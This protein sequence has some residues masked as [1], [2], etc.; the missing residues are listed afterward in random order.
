[1]CHHFLTCQDVALQPVK[2]QNNRTC[3]KRTRQRSWRVILLWHPVLGNIIELIG[4][5]KLHR[6]MVTE[7]INFH[8]LPRLSWQ[9]WH[10]SYT[11]LVR[12]LLTLY[13]F[14]TC[15]HFVKSSNMWRRFWALYKPGRRHQIW[16]LFGLSDR[17][18][19]RCTISGPQFSVR[20]VVELPG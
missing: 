7:S 10:E 5:F 17:G 19:C 18:R 1:M 15:S 12:R 3:S 8:I 11:S 13:L 6:F 20:W 14:F 16:H 2:N 4:I 9:I